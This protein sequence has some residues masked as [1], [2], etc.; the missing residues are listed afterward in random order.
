MKKLTDLPNIGKS[1]ARQ[2][3]QVGIAAPEE[4]QAVGAKEAW[5]R[6]LAIDDSACINRLCAL[7]GALE[8]VRWHDLSAETKADLKA[9]YE[10]HK[11]KG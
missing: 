8:G 2:L 1:V 4:L 7:E 6:I 10:E 5:L 9:F 11:G 3:E